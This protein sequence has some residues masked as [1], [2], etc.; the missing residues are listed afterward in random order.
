[1][2]TRQIE[3]WH[4]LTGQRPQTL[5][6]FMM[7]TDL[8][9][10]RVRGERTATEVGIR[11]ASRFFEYPV[12]QLLD[13]R[14]FGPVTRLPP[15][16]N[17][18]PPNLLI[19]YYYAIKAL[20]AY[21]FDQRTVSNISY[22]LQMSL[23]TNE[24]A[25]IW[26]VL[27]DSSY[28]INT[29]AFA[30]ALT[31]E[32][33]INRTVE[34]IQNA[35]MMDR[36]LT[37][38]NVNP[39]QGLGAVV[40]EQNHNRV[41]SFSVR[42]NFSQ[43]RVSNRDA[44]LLQTICNC[45][46][47]LINFLTLSQPRQC[48]TILDLP[49]GDDWLSSFIQYFSAVTPRESENNLVGDLAAVMTLGKQAGMRGGAI[50]LRSGTRLGLP[51]VLRP[52]EGRLAVTETM[53]RRRGEAVSRFIDS[54]PIRRRARRQDRVRE[55]A[56]SQPPLSP[57]EGPSRREEPEEDI[58]DTLSD[59]SLSREEERANF[60]QEVIE[61]VAAL[62]ESLEEELNPSARASGFFNFGTRMYGLLLQLQRENRLTFQVVLTWLNNFFVLEHVASTLFY[63]NE[64][65]VRTGVAR[66]NLGIQFA[67]VILRGRTD[68]GR[69]L[70]TRVWYNR[71]REAFQ[72]LYNRIVT[73]FIAVTEMTDT[74][75]TF[76]APEEREQLLADMQYVE[77]SGSVDEVIA[78][79]QT[80]AQQTD[81]VELSFRIKFSGL[82]G[83]SQNPVIQRSFE[84]TRAVGI[85]RWRDQQQQ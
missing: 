69:E 80:R 9:N 7:T 36:V 57:G 13:L 79:L 38:L 14:P 17:E 49:L 22:S 52:R 60:N 53:R 37:S 23:A 82:V 68:T 8:N 48:D 63:L 59:Y 73:D 34:Q 29:G 54:L 56:V 35:V 4:R 24:R 6:Y 21:L 70:Y 46:R 47:A 45:R 51:F 12:T 44:T 28:T 15:F 2:A 62:I 33:D 11:W 16:N 85:Q 74:E 64:Q 31:E 55:Q 58:E 42:P 1:M 65:F 61:T 19:G 20:N 32:E 30:R 26:Q 66:R 67:Q 81:S 84:R 5:R 83:Y 40:R 25:M 27:T 78:Q 39:I 50:T 41:A 77:N 43:A 75:T 76:Q 71:E 72:T 18:P 3:A 10:A